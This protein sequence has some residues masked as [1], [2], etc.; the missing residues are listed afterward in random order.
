MHFPDPRWSSQAVRGVV[1]LPLLLERMAGKLELAGREADEH[2]GG[3]FTRLAAGVR[4]FREG[5]VQG[6]EGR[7]Q[8]EEVDAGG[9][10]V[11]VPQKGYF[12]N[13]RFWLNH[14]FARVEEE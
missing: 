7:G 3:V 10:G 11:V 5:V 1:D 6:R 4:A 13:P 8:R 9:D 2:G 12:V 14:L